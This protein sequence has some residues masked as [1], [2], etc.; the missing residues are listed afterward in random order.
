MG[1]ILIF[2]LK[3]SNLHFLPLH[4]TKAKFQ[5]VKRRIFKTVFLNEQFFKGYLMALVSNPEV[6]THIWTPLLHYQDITNVGCQMHLLCQNSSKFQNT[7]VQKG[8][9]K[10]R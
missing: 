7:D 3:Y 4:C 5:E 8:Q 2:H 1:N 10:I 6:L 9:K